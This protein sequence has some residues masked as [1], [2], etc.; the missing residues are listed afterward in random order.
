MASSVRRDARFADGERA[1]RQRLWKRVRKVN[2]ERQVCTHVSTGSYV[3]ARK[4]DELVFAAAQATHRFRPM[5]HPEDGS[6][7]CFGGRAA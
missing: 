1:V 4:M 7:L 6:R 5:H 2:I 3:C